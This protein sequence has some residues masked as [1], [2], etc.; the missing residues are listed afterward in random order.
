MT[1]KNAVRK[2][3]AAAN[4]R[5]GVTHLDLKSAVQT[6]CDGYNGGIGTYKPP[7][8]SNG[9]CE[10]L[11]AARN[12]LNAINEK[13]G[14]QHADLTQAVRALCD[15]YEAYAP[16]YSF[17]VTSDL[18][19]QYAT[20]QSD[21]SK[22]LAYFE[23]Q[24]LPFSCVCGD[25]TW[26]ATMLNTVQYTDAWK[27]GLEDYKD[28]KGDHPVY[29]IGGNHECYTATYDASSKT[30]SSTDT[31]LDADLWK[32]MTGND[33]FY[34]VSCLP[35]DAVNHN[36][37][38]ASLPETDIFIMLSVK[39]ATAPNLFFTENDGEDE[40]AW[41]RRT[42]EANSSKRC[43]LFFHEHDNDD[44]SADPF[45]MYPYGIS[46]GSAQGKAF[47]DL[48]LQYKNVIWFHGHTHTS[49]L[50]EHPP[51]ANARSRGYRSV[52]VPSLQGPRKWIP[53][54]NGFEG[55]ADKAEC[56]VV[57]V[58]ENRIVLNALDLTAVNADGTGTATVLEVFAL[59]TA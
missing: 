27:G 17:G 13:T 42:L 50:E 14:K 2:L 37:Y 18:H 41:L 8:V 43:F 58:Y 48:I 11:N 36:V 54:T 19:L 26:A 57:D 9:R 55:M 25:L 31:G 4:G 3:I 49:F 21:F 59:G 12:I 22:A 16:L 23:K 6:L 51:I 39:K 47:I 56:Y 53:E 38:D 46:E 33:P 15:N 44:K 10:S 30:W 28:I 20:G 45:G 24:R 40:F 5:T 35:D 7:A 1:E 34:T 29:A 32:E 52:N